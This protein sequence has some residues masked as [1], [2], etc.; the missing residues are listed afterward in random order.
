MIS[1]QDHK[2]FTEI[3]RLHS[4]TRALIIM[5]CNEGQ[6]GESKGGSQ[7]FGDLRSAGKASSLEWGNQEVKQ[8]RG[9]EEYAWTAQL[10][11][12]GKLLIQEFIAILEAVASARQVSIVCSSGHH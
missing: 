11:R 5:A 4:G 10:A 3:Y 12:P 7:K 6:F 8:S 1:M 2:T 9:E